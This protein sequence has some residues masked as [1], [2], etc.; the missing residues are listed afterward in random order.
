MSHAPER[1]GRMV[2][3]ALIAVRPSPR[4]A[5]ATAYR[6]RAGV[7]L[8]HVP[9]AEREQ[10]RHRKHLV[11]GMGRNGHR[12]SGGRGSRSRGLAAR[13]LSMRPRSR[14]VQRGAVG[15]GRSNFAHRLKM[16]ACPSATGRTQCDR[17]AGHDRATP[18]RPSEVASGVRSRRCRGAGNRNPRRLIGRPECPLNRTASFESVLAVRRTASTDGSCSAWQRRWGRLLPWGRRRPSRRRR[19]RSPTPPRPW[20]TCRSST[21]LRRSRNWRFLQA[22]SRSAPTA[23]F[24][25]RTAAAAATP[26]R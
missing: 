6:D 13:R 2:K 14:P 8:Q 17:P 15:R 3:R 25:C 19:G 24:R 23:T 18:I 11:D 12:V 21:R 22:C 10:P 16:P 9:R 5:A 26:R 4:C 1:R 7:H 20:V